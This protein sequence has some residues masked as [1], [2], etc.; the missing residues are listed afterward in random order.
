MACLRCISSASHVKCM[1]KKPAFCAPHNGQAPVP[2]PLWAATLGDHV[3]PSARQ[4]SAALWRPVHPCMPRFSSCALAA[5]L[6]SATPPSAVM[7]V[8]VAR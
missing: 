7:P 6:M 1:W 4:F 8:M 2:I 5:Q 3:A